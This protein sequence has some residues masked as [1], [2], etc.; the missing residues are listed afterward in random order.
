MQYLIDSHTFLWY[1]EGSEKL[2]LI[3]RN[4]IDENE[5]K[6]YVSIASLWEIS[7]NVSNNKL[8]VKNSFESIFDDIIHYDFH[9]LSLEFSHLVTQKNLPFHHRDPFDRILISQSI[10]N[11]LDI[12]SVD[13][14]FDQYL[15]STQVKRI[16]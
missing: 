1:S 7:I 15:E 12:I 16:W 11:N 9:I 4:L 10:F 6:I 13:S 2:S 14:V 5:N 8:I 3:A